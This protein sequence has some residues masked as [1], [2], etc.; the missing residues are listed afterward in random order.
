VATRV[1]D[2]RGLICPMT[3]ARVR[4]ELDVLSPGDVLDVTLDH[5]PALSDIRRNAGELGHD[6]KPARTISEGQWRLEI[7][8]GREP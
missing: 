3:W 6:V 7:A 1:L 4:Y 5:R 8:V 2:I